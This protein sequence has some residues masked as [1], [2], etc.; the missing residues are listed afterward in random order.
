MG[1]QPPPKS[2]RNKA[3]EKN[4]PSKK[5]LGTAQISPDVGY[6]RLRCVYGSIRSGVYHKW[7]ARQLQIRIAN[8]RAARK[9]NYLHLI[10]PL[11][12]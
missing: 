3:D 6:F 7:L 9:S 1:L 8:G 4:G 5:I 11:K 2:P 12:S 10:F